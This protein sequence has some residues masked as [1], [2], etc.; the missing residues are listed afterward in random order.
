[1]ITINI[2]YFGKNKNA[3]KFVDEMIQSG[4]VQRIREEKGNKR[5]EYFY[6]IDNVETVLLIDSWESQAA[7]DA[8]HASKTMEEIAALREKYDLHMKVEKYVSE[9][10]NPENAKYIRK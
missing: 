3:R 10:D 8:D 4:I 7:L 5:Y 6:P 2:Y 9:D 1:M